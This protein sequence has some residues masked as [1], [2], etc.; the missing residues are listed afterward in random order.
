M[1]LKTIHQ[2]IDSEFFIRVSKS[3]IINSKHIISFDNHTIYMNEFEIPIGETYRSEFM[4][5]YSKG[6]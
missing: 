6:N 5:K 3:Y 1:N 2:K 4:L